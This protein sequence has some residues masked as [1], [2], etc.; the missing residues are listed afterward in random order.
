MRKSKKYI[1][2]KDLP[3]EPKEFS[4]L[5]SLVSS[6]VSNARIKRFVRDNYHH[7]MIY[8]S[9]IG[10]LRKKL[11]QA[12]EDDVSI[13]DLLKGKKSH[14]VQLH[15]IKPMQLVNQELARMFR[16]SVTNTLSNS[17]ERYIIQLLHCYMK[18]N[19]LW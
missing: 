16:K 10:L 18:S 6:N 17:D 12:Y 14:V 7:K 3:K 1:H 8:D 5:I 4:E 2:L 13:V 19:Y 15:Q 9:S 11:Y